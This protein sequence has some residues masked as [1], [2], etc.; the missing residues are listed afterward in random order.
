MAGTE[1]VFIAW[2]DWVRSIA[3]SNDACSSLSPNSMSYRGFV[4]SANPGI[5]ICQN[6]AIPRNSLSCLLL[7]DVGMQQIISFFLFFFWSQPHES[8]FQTETK[9]L[10]LRAYRLEPFS[11]IFHMLLSIGGERGLVFFP[12]NLSVSG[13]RATNHLCITATYS[14]IILRVL[15][16]ISNKELS[17]EGWKS[18]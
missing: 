4:F 17:K 16:Q 7:L 2:K 6:P 13:Y 9:I 12:S 8:I 18:F 5:Q 11:I 14:G 10:Y 15:S 3:Q 1:W